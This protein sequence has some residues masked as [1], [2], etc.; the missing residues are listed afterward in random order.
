[1]TR[2]RGC[3]ARLHGLA[4]VERADDAG[5]APLLPDDAGGHDLELDLDDEVAGAP[6]RRAARSG[7][8]GV[9][10]VAEMRSDIAPAEPRLDLVDVL[11]AG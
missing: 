7:G 4:L 1:M 3:A 10:A 8:T 11:T 5:R 2:A 9:S 6:A